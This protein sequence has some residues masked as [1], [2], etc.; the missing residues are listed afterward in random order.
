[1]SIE[2]V[3]RS[4]NEAKIHFCVLRAQETR[5]VPIIPNHY[6]TASSSEIRDMFIDGYFIGTISL[7]QSVAEGLSK[8]LCKRKHIACSKK[9]LVRVKKLLSEDIITAEAGAAFEKI[10][11]GRNDFHHMNEN[12]ESDY[13]A[14]EIKAKSN[15]DSLFMIEDEIFGHSFDNGK[16]VP[17]NPE[18]W[19]I[20][21]DGT[22][23]VF[24][25]FSL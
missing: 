20:G 25:R 21:T 18:Y 16:V 17:K 12:V 10:E 22:T 11:D 13:S 19:D 14:L 7:S 9:H 15:V 1:M 23:K 8:F 3:L 6:F 4:R 5:V 24:L 2:K